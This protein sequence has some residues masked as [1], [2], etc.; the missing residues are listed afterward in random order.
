MALNMGALGKKIGPLKKHYKWQDVVLYGESGRDS[1]ILITYM[2]KISRSFLLFSGDWMADSVVKR[3]L[4][5]T[6]LCPTVPRI[7]LLTTGLL[8]ISRLFIDFP[9]T[10]SNCI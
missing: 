1:T 9:E 5:I 6:F 10:Y 7:F 4:G 8:K 2:K 3:H